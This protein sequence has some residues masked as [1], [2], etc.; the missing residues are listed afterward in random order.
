MAAGLRGAKQREVVGKIR[1]VELK[2]VLASIQRAQPMQSEVTQSR[3]GREVLADQ[4]A[5]GA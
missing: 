1:V 3:F 4:L 5:D 2:E